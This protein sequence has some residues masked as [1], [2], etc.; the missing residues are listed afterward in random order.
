MRLRGRKNRTPL[1]DMLLLYGSEKGFTVWPAA[2]ERLIVPLLAL[3]FSL[4]GGLT[5]LMKLIYLTARL[6]PCPKLMALSVIPVVLAA[7]LTVGDQAANIVPAVLS[8]TPS[9][10]RSAR[11]EVASYPGAYAGSSRLSRWSIPSTTRFG[12]RSWPICPMAFN[13]RNRPIPGFPLD[14]H[15]HPQGR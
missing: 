6:L 5:H 10:R 11:G 1:K 12:A 14:R 15:S 9:Q 3:M 8:M 7:S 4:L 13:P 2:A